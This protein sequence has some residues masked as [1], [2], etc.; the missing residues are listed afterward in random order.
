[1][2]TESDIANIGLL[3]K[4]FFIAKASYFVEIETLSPLR[5][6][7]RPVVAT[8]S[9]LSSPLSTIHHS[10]ALLPSLIS[11]YSAIESGRITHTEEMF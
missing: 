8:T 9:P 3:I 1:M 6:F 10:P 2:I 11:R 4:K 7:C 5:N